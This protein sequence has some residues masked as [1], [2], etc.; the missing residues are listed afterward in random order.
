MILDRSIE[1]S[2]GTAEGSLTPQALWGMGA[3]VKVPSVEMII[4][5]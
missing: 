1:D 3:T 4:L 5:R 2:E